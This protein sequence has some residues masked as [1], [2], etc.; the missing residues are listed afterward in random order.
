M[1]DIAGGDGPK[2]G[3]LEAMIESEGLQERVTLVGAVPHEEARQFL[4]RH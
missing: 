4:V 3:V 2:R 1:L